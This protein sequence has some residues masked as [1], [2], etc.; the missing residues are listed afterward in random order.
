MC[1]FRRMF[2]AAGECLLIGSLLLSAFSL[3]AQSEADWWYFG[4]YAGI[5][6]TPS[7]PVADT[8]G[9]LETIEGVASISD[10]SGNLLFYTDGGRVWNRNHQPMPNGFGLLGH[11][12]SSQ[13]AIVVPKP[14]DPT[15]FYVFTVDAMA[16]SNG[17][18]YSLVDMNLNA[19]LGDIDSTQKNIPLL[20][21]VAEKLTAIPFANHMGFWVLACPYGSDSIASFP[22]TTNGVNTTPVRSSSG[23]FIGNNSIET[24]G[25]MKASPEGS[26][27]AAAQYDHQFLHLMQFDRSTGKVSNPIFVPVPIQ[28]YGLEF[29]PNGQK[30]YT[31]SE[32]GSMGTSIFQFD[33]ST[34]DLLSILNSRA[35]LGSTANYGHLQ[36]GPDEKIYVTKGGAGALDVIHNPNETGMAANFQN[37][38]VILG[39]RITQLGL[40]NFVQSFFFSPFEF[41]GL[42]LGDTTFFVADSIGIDSV[43]W[44]FGDPA[45]GVANY[46]QALQPFFQYADTGAYEVKLLSYTGSLV[47]TAALLVTILPIPSV[48]LGNDTTICIGD[49]FLLDASK[50]G[51]YIEWQDGS[52]AP[53]YTVDTAGIYWVGL[54]NACG[55]TRDSLEVEQDTLLVPFSLGPDTTL[56]GDSSLL[57]VPILVEGDFL[58]QDGSTGSSF[59][60]N[61][62][63]TI[64]LTKTNSCNSVSDTLIFNKLPIPQAALPNDTLI[65]DGSTLDLI[66]MQDPEF[67]YLWSDSSSTADLSIIQSGSYWLEVAND[68]GTVR[69]SISVAI[70]QALTLNFPE[71]TILCK[72]GSFTLNATNEGA[73][74]L[75]QDGS[76]DAVFVVETWG[77]YNVTV[78][79]NGCEAT[80]FISVAEDV[81]PCFGF[82]CLEE[83]TNVFTPNG[84]G[85]N[86]EWKPKSFCEFTSYQLSVYNRWGNILFQSDRPELAWDGRSNGIEVQ[87]GVFFWVLEIAPQLAPNQSPH[88]VQGNVTLLR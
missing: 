28:P 27:L 2:S 42:C 64:W 4:S 43:W 8:N 76:I 50:P 35:D 39:G 75:W 25:Y 44:D 29:S 66:V 14:A 32:Y 21:Q 16:G 83:A 65:C 3:Q 12:S 51:T 41:S 80:D 56:C 88:I 54:S 47:D 68:C 26:V 84:D 57:I 10:V 70:E 63:D 6:F 40:P 11:S 24:L 86:D 34:Y 71:D 23:L 18:S 61:Q 46:S 9:A 22:V 45:A 53:T 33:I 1:F 13:S 87:E 77:E 82:D 78:T 67:A 36:L 38:G 19:G 15:K 59:N 85:I 60:A 81:N 62:P 72:G 52:F 58:W 31:S 49:T 17:L 55:V 7:G 48:N 73:S 20:S 79:R 69:D 37:A 5:H 30:L 74:Y